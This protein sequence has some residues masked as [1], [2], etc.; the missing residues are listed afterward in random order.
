MQ[1]CKKNIAMQMQCKKKS[2]YMPHRIPLYKHDQISY[3]FA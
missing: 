3:K 1:K 2:K